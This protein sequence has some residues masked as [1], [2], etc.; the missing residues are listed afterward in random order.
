MK[1]KDFR[2]GLLDSI[3]SP[4]QV[5]SRSDST[6][7]KTGPNSLVSNLGNRIAFARARAVE[8]ATS[9]RLTIVET[10]TTLPLLYGA[11]LPRHASLPRAP[12]RSRSS[13]YRSIVSRVRERLALFRPVNFASSVSDLGLDCLMIRS[14]TQFGFDRIRPKLSAG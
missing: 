3:W 5:I 1:T 12:A 9:C 7:S 11:W 6:A 2:E 13:P 4:G 14:N 10:E 8:S